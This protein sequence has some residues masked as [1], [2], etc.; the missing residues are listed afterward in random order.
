MQGVFRSGY[1]LLVS[2]SGEMKREQANLTS[3]QVSPLS[4]TFLTL[5]TAQVSVFHLHT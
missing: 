2:H 1:I 5:S 3:K 4:A